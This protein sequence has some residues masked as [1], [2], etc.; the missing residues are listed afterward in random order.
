[1]LDNYTVTEISSTYDSYSCSTGAGTRLSGSADDGLYNTSLGFNFSYFADLKGPTTQT[2]MDTNGKLMWTNTDSDYSASVEEMESQYIIAAN[3]QDLGGDAHNNE[4]ICVNQGT[5]PHKYAV[6]RWDSQWYDGDGAAQMEVVLYENDSSIL[7]RY[8][9][10]AA[11]SDTWIRGIS[12]ASTTYSNYEIGSDVYTNDSNRAFEYTPVLQATAKKII[13][14]D[15]SYSLQIINQTVVGFVN[16]DASVNVTVGV[17]SVFN[18]IALT[19]DSSTIKLYLNGT[20]QDSAAFSDSVN[21]TGNNV[22]IGTKL[23]G[24]ID[25]VLIF[26]R[27]LTANQILALFENRSDLLVSQET[28]VNDVWSFNATPNDGSGN[29]DTLASN[30]LTVNAVSSPSAVPEF[31]DYVLFLILIVV[32]GG[33]FRIR[34]KR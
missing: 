33:F 22:T 11:H 5:S 32:I 26:N 16:G 23:N 27:S 10:I 28:V 20:L 24:T 12:N 15:E 17:D 30:S 2:F 31:S 21:I 6:F 1:M 7:I 18:H 13:E 14:K 25:D 4:Y 3:W 9:T 19:Y 29:G 34:E 8:G